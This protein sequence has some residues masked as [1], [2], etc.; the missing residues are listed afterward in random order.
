MAAFSLF[1]GTG[2]V[3]RNLALELRR[4]GHSVRVI[5]RDFPGRGE[6]LGHIVYCVGLTAD[7]RER[8]AD[9][10]RAHACVLADVLEAHR[11]E[12]FLY[13]SSTRVYAGNPSTSEVSTLYV[14]P[15]IP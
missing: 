14:R 5:G 4:C 2:L 15:D 13:L 7:F 8:R 11:F 3:G 10:V 9:T 6:T 1:G 12:S